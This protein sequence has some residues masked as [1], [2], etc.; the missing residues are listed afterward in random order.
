MTDGG[1]EKA[2]PNVAG[3]PSRRLDAAGWDERWVTADTPWDLGTAAPPIARALGTGFVAPDPNRRCRALVIGCG[4]G[5]DARAAA[6][7]GFETTGIDLSA[8]A[9]ARA[10][11]IAEQAASSARFVVAD[12]FALPA[13]LRGNDLVVEHTLF[14]AIDPADRDRYVDAAADALAP[15]GRMLALF[16]LIRPETGPP[17]GTTEAELRHRFGRRFRF[18]HTECPPDSHPRG[19]G[20]ELLAVLAKV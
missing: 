1:P 4:A 2:F 3:V 11:L 5:H 19:A 13:E 6:D 14:C 7:A 20:K 18:V 15:G 16:W 8:T 9:V 17:F 10:K 12:F